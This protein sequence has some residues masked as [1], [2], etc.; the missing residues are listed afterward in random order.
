VVAPNPVTNAEFTR[1]L[2]A[3]L[4]RPTFMPVP[5]LAIKALFG[6]EMA[7]EMIFGGQRLVP[8]R[9]LDAGFEFRDPEVEGALRTMLG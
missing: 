3:A 1:A 9:L 7:E 2:G 8:K 5:S 4:G 6:S